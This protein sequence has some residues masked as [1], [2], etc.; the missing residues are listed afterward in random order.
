MVSEL[1]AAAKRLMKLVPDMK[2]S[3]VNGRRPDLV[4]STNT[5]LSFSSVYGVDFNS[6]VEE[7]KAINNVVDQLEAGLFRTPSKSIKSIYLASREKQLSL[8]F[9]ERFLPLSWISLQFSYVFN[10][11]CY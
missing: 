8:P 2:C 11:Q 6:V 9:A 1:S 7:E 4:S 3:K 5:N 10:H